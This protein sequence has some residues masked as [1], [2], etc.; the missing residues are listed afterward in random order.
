M[1]KINWTYE[2]ECWL[3][4]IYDYI[5]ADNPHRLPHQTIGRCRCGEVQ[6]SL[7]GCYAYD[8]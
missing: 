5:A 8:L 1:A 2:A 7:T 4:D 6:S 3:K